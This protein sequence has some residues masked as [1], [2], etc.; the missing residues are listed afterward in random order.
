MRFGAPNRSESK[1]VKYALDPLTFF[2]R[3]GLYRPCRIAG[4][5]IFY[6]SG[7]IEECS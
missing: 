3:Q 6:S 2:R 4:H 1:G 5:Q 7:T